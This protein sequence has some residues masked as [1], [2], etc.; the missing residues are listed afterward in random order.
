MENKAKR[1]RAYQAR[2]QLACIFLSYEIHTY[3]YINDVKLS[4][5]G[6]YTCYYDYTPSW[7]SQ[8]GFKNVK[9]VPGKNY[10]TKIV[11]IQGNVL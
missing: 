11:Y 6:N 2:D 10:V 8:K 4:D 1:I 3:L 9:I 7:T 5:E